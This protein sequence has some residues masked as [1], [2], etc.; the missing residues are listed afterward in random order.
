MEA[1]K[2]PPRVAGRERAFVW[3]DT[4]ALP[5]GEGAEEHPLRL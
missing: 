3:V 5:F 4:Q 1:T 2:G